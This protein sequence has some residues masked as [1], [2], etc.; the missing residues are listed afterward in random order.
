MLKT[1][2]VGDDPG[3]VLKLAI[4][5][6]VRKSVGSALLKLLLS[7]IFVAARHFAYRLRPRQPFTVMADDACTIL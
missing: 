4:R 3:A 6:D 7:C 5:Q 2:M 1:T